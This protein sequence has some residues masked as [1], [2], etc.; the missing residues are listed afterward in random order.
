MRR[1]GVLAVAGLMALAPAACGSGAGADGGSSDA[2]VA[3]LMPD[4]ASTRYEQHDPP[5][6]DARDEGAVLGLQG[7][8]PER[9]RRRRQAAAAGNSVITQGVKV[10]RDRPGRLRRGR[11]DRPGRAGRRASRSSPT[12][13]RSRKSRPTTTSRSTTRRSA[14]RSPS[15]W[16]TTSRR[17]ASASKGGILQVNGSPT[18]AAAGLIKKGVHEGVD[19]SGYKTLAEFDTPGLGAAEGTGLGRRPDL[20]VPRPDRRRGRRERRHR[21]RRDRGVQG[22][23]HQPGPAGHRQRRRARRDAADHLRRPVQHHLQADQDRRRR[24]PPRS[25]TS[26]SRAS[27]RSRRRRCSA[28]PPRCSRPT[29]VTKD[30]VKAE[31]IDTEIKAAVSLQ[32]RLRQ[33]LRPLTADRLAGAVTSARPAG[34]HDAE[35]GDR[36]RSVC[37][38]RGISQDL[39][40]GGGADRR[41]PRRRRRPGRRARRRQRRRQ[42]D[43]GQGARPACTRRRRH[44]HLRAAAR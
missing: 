33:G 34:R 14:S 17:R 23:R 42:V 19:A 12:T 1:F 20:P 38:S 35:R 44:D 24:P 22:R 13:G 5:L 21:R 39:R 27:S 3:F 10:D 29:V 15:R 4:Q 6:F 37:S 43:A 9:R 40:R 36:T 30:N 11:L 7:D 41:R 18:D 28:R 2:K 26:C 8:L 16:S 25:P 31:I 32:R